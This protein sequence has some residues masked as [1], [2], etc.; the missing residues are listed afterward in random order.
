MEITTV[1]LDLAKKV[2]QVHGI[3]S[4]GEVSVRKT[5]RRS[6]VRR[7]FE[8]PHKLIGNQVAIFLG[9]P[10]HTPGKC[11]GAFR[12]SKVI[13]RFGDPKI[14]IPLELFFQRIWRKGCR[15]RIAAGSLQPQPRIFFKIGFGNRRFDAI[16]RIDHRG[17]AG[18]RRRRQLIHRVRQVLAFVVRKEALFLGIVDGVI[19]CE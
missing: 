18:E 19:V 10:D 1:G 17:Q 11:A 14:A 8:Q 9:D 5:L 12:D 15:Q 4:A 13:G 3:N 7:F 2:F 16:A 6:Q